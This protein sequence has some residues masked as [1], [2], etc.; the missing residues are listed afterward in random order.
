M[1]LTSEQ[2]IEYLHRS[3]TAVDGLWFMKAEEA[4]SFEIALDLDEK[5]W[6]ILP[7]IQARKIKTLTGRTQGL[8]DLYECF[9]AKLTL[10]RL[11]FDAV[12]DDQG[13]EFTITIRRCP[14]L[15][16]LR[17]SKREHLAEKIG[18]RI[19]TAE[20]STWAR[21]FGPNIHFDLKSQICKNAPCCTLHFTTT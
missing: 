9:I 4:F 12:K 15:E 10:D 6:H 11:E 5:V 16:L 20:Y 17:D 7:K 1:D 19:C 3:Y 13:K 8:D 14:W 21:E 2:I 18:S